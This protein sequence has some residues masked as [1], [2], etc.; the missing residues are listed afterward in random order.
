MDYNG[1]GWLGGPSKLFSNTWKPRY[2]GLESENIQTFL[3]QNKYR[4]FVNNP[5]G[6]ILKIISWA[7]GILEERV[8]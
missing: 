2:G 5:L 1:L 7:W 6:T 3:N 4:I 8:Y